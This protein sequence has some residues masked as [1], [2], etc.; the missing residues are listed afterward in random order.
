MNRMT[1]F[2]IILGLTAGPFAPAWVAFAHETPPASPRE[3][4]MRP[5]TPAPES[6]N[7][8]AQPARADAP[9]PSQPATSA[10]GTNNGPTYAAHEDMELR[11]F[12]LQY[13]NAGMLAETLKQLF[14][15]DDLS[16]VPDARTNSLIVRGPSERLRVVDALAL[17]LDELPKIPSTRATFSRHSEKSGAGAVVER[18][19]N[20]SL[21]VLRKNYEEL[22]QQAARLAEQYGALP[23][24]A[25]RT[26]GDAEALKQQLAAVFKQ[27]FAVRQQLQRAE[28]ARLRQRLARIEQQIATRDRIKD[29]I[30]GRR[31]E[32]ALNPELQREP[33][34]P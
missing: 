14:R 6:S 20:S 12:S 23:T 18:I 3:E 5:H 1:R 27:A 8:A 22:Q 15:E 17:R 21:S 7:A 30:I 32:E 16:I 28:L 9:Q 2:V 25:T 24:K 34:D 4:E 33:Q 11:I 29:E 31:V 26:P 13:A 10:A 19:D